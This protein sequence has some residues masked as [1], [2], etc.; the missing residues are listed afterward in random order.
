MKLRTFLF[1]FLC[2]TASAIAKPHPPPSGFAIDI[3]WLYMSNPIDRP[4]FIEQTGFS[5]NRRYANSPGWHSGYRLDGMYDF[6]LDDALDIRWTHF[7]TFSHSS[8]VSSSNFDLST[9][10][11]PP[12][13][14]PANFGSIKDTFSFHAL[15]LIYAR[16]L[17]QCCPFTVWVEGGLQYAHIALEENVFYNSTI[18]DSANYSSK[19]DGVGLELGTE[20]EFALLNNFALELRAQTGLLVSKR[21]TSVNYSGMIG[22][23]PVSGNV[24]PDPIWDLIPTVDMRLGLNYSLWCGCLLIDFEA[25]Y[26]FFSYFNSI[27]RVD[28]RVTLE[29]FAFID[30]MMHGFYIQTGISF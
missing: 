13:S 28:D 18:Q 7:P 17:Y 2:F 19:T 27:T 3:E 1:C 30:Y 6:C 9:L 15:E 29:Q 25:G 5:S 20:M 14:E 8:S 16:Q 21:R 12:S 22:K 10:L 4:Y 23:S 26:E 24:Q 11:F